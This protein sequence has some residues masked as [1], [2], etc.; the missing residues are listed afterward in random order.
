MEARPSGALGTGHQRD[1]KA[2]H[3]FGQR[4]SPA[5]QPSG[6]R[7]ET[8]TLWRLPTAAQG[9]NFINFILPQSNLLS[10]YLALW[11][12]ERK[13]TSLRWVQKPHP[14]PLL[15]AG[16]TSPAPR[17]A[18]PGP[19]EEGALSFSAT[20][21]SGQ[22]ESCRAQLT[23]PM[24]H[25][26]TGCFTVVGAGRTRGGV[27]KLGRLS[28]CSPTDLGASSRLPDDPSR[29]PPVP[30]PLPA[31]R[32]DQGPGEAG[33]VRSGGAAG[34][35][36]SETASEAWVG[37]REHVPCIYARTS[38]TK[39]WQLQGYALKFPAKRGAWG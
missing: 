7:E 1:T 24:G 32:V 25:S 36:K 8:E 38:E 10:I 21:G 33:V 35:E 19:C 3:H 34:E 14:G 2:F 11:E 20:P 16:G 15:L 37:A 39:G 26:P 6:G 17:H 31:H 30:V 18:A 13:V 12:E 9:A 27:F 5:M 28:P 22:G 4:C 23:V 29:F